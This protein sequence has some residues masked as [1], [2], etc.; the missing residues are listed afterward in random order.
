M[1]SLLADLE[2]GEALARSLG[3]F[4]RVFDQFY[5]SLIEVGE[6]SGTLEENLDFLSEQLAKNLALRKKIQGALLYP[7]L[8]FLAAA[9]MGGFISLFILPQLVGFFESFAIDLP[10]TTRILLVVANVMKDYGVALFGGLIVGT[11][12]VCFIRV[13]RPQEDT[14]LRYL[15]KPPPTVINFWRLCRVKTTRH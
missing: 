9:I 4:P 3:K 5:I 10:L 2:N 12:M 11:A 7:A 14:C 13:F 15:P 8:V 6:E 1:R